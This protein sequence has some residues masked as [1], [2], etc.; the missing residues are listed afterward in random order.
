MNEFEPKPPE[1][2]YAELHRDP[3]TGGLTF[4]EASPEDNVLYALKRGQP[5]DA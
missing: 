5:F 1:T 3:V 4:I 2:T